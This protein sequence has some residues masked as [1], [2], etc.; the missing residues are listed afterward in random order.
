MTSPHEDFEQQLIEAL[1][2]EASL[3]M[4]MTDTPRELRRWKENLKR[5]RS[6]VRVAAFA[7]AAAAIAGAVLGA[8]LI[9]TGTH[10][11]APTHPTTPRVK[12]STFG[13]PPSLPGSTPVTKVSGPV[14]VGEDAFGV[15]WAT[16]QGSS[17]GHLYRL[18]AKTGAIVTDVRYAGAIDDLPPLRAGNVVLVPTQP[19]HGHSGYLVYN[20][21]G[22]PTGQFIPATTPGPGAGDAT[23]GW[24]P[25][26]N[27]TVG[28]VSAS[29]RLT[30]QFR[31]TQTAITAVG[32]GD[33]SLWVGSLG[34]S[35]AIR[36]DP[37]SGK[38]I[39]RV[40]L[41]GDPVQ[42]L[43]TP[44][45]VYATTDHFQI[46]RID[47]VTNDVLAEATAGIPIDR[48]S[49]VF[50]APAPNGNLWAS[51][52]QG[53]IVVLD[54][55]DLTLIRGMQVYPDTRDGGISGLAVTTARVFLGD[56]DGT[57]TV[58]FPVH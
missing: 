8:T 24:A 38:V 12:T 7:A 18:D 32:F 39:A 16:G 57:R 45:S 28:H 33:G 56:V 52:D 21:A 27:R 10:K 22:Q 49:F 11:T 29:G 58:S 17:S 4:T 43:V 46:V 23:G 54:P 15:V 41:G 40:R 19:K 3:T 34:S 53:G 51:P 1:H 30:Q 25:L 55:R 44:T 14:N 2:Q 13:V 35:A 47:P 26:T 6:T 20:S 42:F 9:G 37:V 36:L 5:R 48:H 50:L 31:V